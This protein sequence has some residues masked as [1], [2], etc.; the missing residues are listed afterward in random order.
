MKEFLKREPVRRAIRTFIQAAAGYIV[1]NV[2]TTDFETKNAVFAFG[3]AAIAAGI[4]A[5]MNRGENG[6]ND[7]EG[8]AEK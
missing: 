1:V 4:A 8:D 3:A 6:E 7:T 2:M 5:V